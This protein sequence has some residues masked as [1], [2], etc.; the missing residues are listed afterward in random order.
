MGR[1]AGHAGDEGVDVVV[2]QHRGHG[3]EIDSAGTVEGEGAVHHQT[4]L[5]RQAH[6]GEQIPG[7]GGGVQ[8]PVYIGVQGADA[9]LVNTAIAV[10]DDPVMM[11]QAFRLAVEAGVMARRAVPGTRSSYAQAPSPLTG[12]LEASA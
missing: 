7:A 10:A 9:V 8:T 1:I 4:G 12:F 5:L 3:I 11:A 2:V 6:A